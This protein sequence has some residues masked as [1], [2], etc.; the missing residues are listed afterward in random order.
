MYKHNTARRWHVAAHNRQNEHQEH[1]RIAHFVLRHM[2][3]HGGLFVIVFT[4]VEL[5]K[6][7]LEN[8]QIV[9]AGFAV[10][11]LCFGW[12]AHPNTELKHMTNTS[13]HEDASHKNNKNIFSIHLCNLPQN[14]G[15]QD[16]PFRS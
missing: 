5:S 16:L 7:H 9:R 4:C 13:T 6:I 15:N 2:K 12:R 8:R 11:G 10:A 14:A 1:E 3:V